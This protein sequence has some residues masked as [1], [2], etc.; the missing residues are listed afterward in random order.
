MKILKTKG[1]HLTN[2]IL[3][4]DLNKRCALKDLQSCT[5]HDAIKKNKISSES[6]QAC[7]IQFT[8]TCYVCEWH[9]YS[10]EKCFLGVDTRELDMS[11]PI[12]LYIVCEQITPDKQFNMTEV[13]VSTIKKIL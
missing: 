4:E 10:I 13:V 9:K 5:G 1:E 6:I 12:N 11:D 8:Y 2:I 3:Q 7:I